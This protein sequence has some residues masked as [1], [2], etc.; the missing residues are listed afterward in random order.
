MA[1]KYKMDFALTIRN[2]SISSAPS[3]VTTDINLFWRPVI[4]S[5]LDRHRRALVAA[6]VDLESSAIARYLEVSMI[7][8]IFIVVVVLSML[9]PLFPN[10]RISAEFRNRN[11][12]RMTG[13]FSSLNRA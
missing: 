12:P 5:G 7:K 4:P 8:V 1:V 10:Y 2:F 6:N 11:F 3:S 13:D 9:G